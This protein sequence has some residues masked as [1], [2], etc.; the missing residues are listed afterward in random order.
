VLLPILYLL[1]VLLL[2]AYMKN[3]MARQVLALALISFSSCL[4]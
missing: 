4:D 3:M 2:A 1:L